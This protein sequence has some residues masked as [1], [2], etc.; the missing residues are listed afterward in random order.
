MHHG[1]MSTSG[2]G[3]A[4]IT[5]TMEQLEII[6]N[7]VRQVTTQS[8][9]IFGEKDF[10]K[11]TARFDR[12]TRTA[13]EAFLDNVNTYRKCIGASDGNAVTGLIILLT[14]EAATWRQ[15]QKSNV[16]NWN[17][18][19]KLLCSPFGTNMPPHK[20]YGEI[21]ALQQDE[22][23][24]TEIFISRIRALFARLPTPQLEFQKLDMLYGGLNRRIRERLSRD[25]FTTYE[26]IRK[27]RTIEAMLT[28]VPVTAPAA[29]T[30][31]DKTIGEKVS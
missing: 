27:A 21:W 10:T 4:P 11:C 26:L 5:M 1:E 23:T 12:A 14:G 7:S 17:M 29:K 18:A 16:H 31:L 19:E 2:P 9:P 28:E 25:E 20:I 15:G 6:I 3:A 30:V 22:S 8:P 24:L 13:V